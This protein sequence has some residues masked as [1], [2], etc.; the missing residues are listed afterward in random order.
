VNFCGRG[1][2]SVGSELTVAVVRSKTL[3]Q[4]ATS[5]VPLSGVMVPCTLTVRGFATHVTVVM[6]TVPALAVLI[7]RH[8]NHP[9]TNPTANPPRLQTI[10]VS[11]KIRAFL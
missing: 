2:S 5:V 10:A 4:M 8:T 3:A 1:N 7:H 9:A 11:D 6:P